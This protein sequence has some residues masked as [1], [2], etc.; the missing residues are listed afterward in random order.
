M[1]DSKTT[2]HLRVMIDAIGYESAMKVKTA[3]YLAGYAI[4]K[5][6]E[7]KWPPGNLCPHGYPNTV[8]CTPLRGVADPCRSCVQFGGG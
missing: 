1:V 3:L 5:V 7:P 2:N 6:S 8:R 4:T